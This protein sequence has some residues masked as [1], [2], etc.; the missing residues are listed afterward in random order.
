MTH[1]HTQM[2][3]V[4]SNVR[5]EVNGSIPSYW[6]GSQAGDAQPIVMIHK[7][8]RTMVV[9]ARHSCEWLCG[10]SPSEKMFPPM[11]SDCGSNKDIMCTAI[12]SRKPE[13]HRDIVN[14]VTLCR[15]CLPRRVRWITDAHLKEIQYIVK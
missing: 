7:N 11:C 5:V 14:A 10:Q 13:P 8:E 3:I 2:G 12:K 15:N 1:F 9:V 6:T 4:Q